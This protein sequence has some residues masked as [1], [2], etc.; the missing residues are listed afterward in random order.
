MILE[1]V[2]IKVMRGLESEFEASFSEAQRL[3]SNS[4]GYISHELLRG[5]E[6]SNQYLLL[7]R[8][9]SVEANTEGFRK[10]DEYQHWKKLLHPFY[11]PFPDVKHFTPVAGIGSTETPDT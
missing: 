6:H 5:L 2:S 8:W 11:D 4:P 1:A 10:S 9:Q 7:V 3:I